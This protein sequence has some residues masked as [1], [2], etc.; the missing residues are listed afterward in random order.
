MT[1]EVES[2]TAWCSSLGA[3]EEWHACDAANGVVQG[4]LADEMGISL[5]RALMEFIRTSF[6][7]EP[8]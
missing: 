5:H 7:K 1:L 8:H 6:P 3:G 4:R 2:L